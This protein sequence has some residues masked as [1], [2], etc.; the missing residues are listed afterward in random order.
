MVKGF[1]KTSWDN[2]EYE[3]KWFQQGKDYLL[4]N[5][6]RKNQVAS[7]AKRNR[8]ASLNSDNLVHE[9]PVESESSENNQVKLEVQ[10][11]VKKQEIMEKELGTVK[12]QIESLFK[13]Q[14]IVISMFSAL[15]PTFGQHLHQNVIEQG[16][17][18]EAEF[19]KEPAERVKNG[20]GME[21]VVADHYTGQQ[22]GLF[23]TGNLVENTENLCFLEKL[24]AIDENQELQGELANQQSNI[25]MELEGLMTQAELGGYI[26]FMSEVEFQETKPAI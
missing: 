16:V 15:L 19:E 20:N 1:K 5:I 26:E 10:K 11:L 9:A 3:N 24:M 14:K 17:I 25:V 8:V 12:G 13:Q 23:D 18:E 6:K 21:L 2:W 4:V 22:N 7:V